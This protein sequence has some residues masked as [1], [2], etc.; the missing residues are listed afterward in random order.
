VCDSLKISHIPLRQ[1]Q[2][3]STKYI[4]LCFESLQL[5]KNKKSRQVLQLFGTGVP[6]ALGL[7]NTLASWTCKATSASQNPPRLGRGARGVIDGGQGILFQLYR[8]VQGSEK[9]NCDLHEQ[10]KTKV[11]EGSRG[12]FMSISVHVNCLLR[13]CSDVD[14][15][16]LHLLVCS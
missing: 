14:M 3:F 9:P 15:G 1:S 12:R 7:R 4:Y 2:I 16:S 6:W 5:K 10:F 11:A 8:S 13:I